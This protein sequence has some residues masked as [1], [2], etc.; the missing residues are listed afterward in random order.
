MI[1]EKQGLFKKWNMVLII[2]T[3]DLV[4]YGT[5]L[6]R[7]GVLSS[8]HAFAQSS[9]GPLFF[10][11]I[12]ITFAVSLG[13]LLYRWNSLQ[14]EGEFKSI[15]SRETAFL[16]NNVFFIIILFFTFVGVNA[17]LISELIT[18]QKITVGPDWYNRNTG[19]FWAGLVLLM[20]IAPLTAWG[21]ST[22]RTLGKAIWKPFI[23]SLILLGGIIFLGVR[24]ILAL[25]GFYLAA[26][27]ACV[28]LYDYGRGIAARH[29]R[30]GENYLLALAH[31]AGRY[32]RRYGG[33][34][35]HLGIVLVALGVIGTHFYQSQT[36]GTLTQG[37]SLQVGGYTLTYKSLAIFDTADGRNVARAIVDVSRNGK[38]LTELHPRRDYYY[39]SQQPMTIPGVRSSVADD[40]YV[41]LVDWEPISSQ[42]ATFKVYINPLINWLW[43]GGL[44]FILGALVAAWPD[45]EREPA[46][47]KETRRVSLPTKA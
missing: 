42:G 43:A 10:A 3:Y 28:T 18:G 23:A 19:P 25:I 6:T 47:A 16:V 20:G 2:L 44:I 41:V 37:Q 40:V 15:I 8:V 4:I 17:P 9:I 29:R 27:T 24:N 46:K 39:V 5:F 33:Y 36:Q 12:G 14:S 13:L 11:F 26:F 35:I 31:L 32:R 21:H 22:A 7:S 1:Q 34:I 30:S 45:A 38:F